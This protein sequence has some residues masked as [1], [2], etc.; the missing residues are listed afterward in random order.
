MRADRR[1]WGPALSAR[2]DARSHTNLGA[3]LHLNGKYSEAA[4]SYK[5]ALR[6]Q[7]D[8]ITTLTNLHKL[9]SVMT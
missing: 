8:D 2:N 5:E 7:P 1:G 4:N 9:H 6:L 3:I